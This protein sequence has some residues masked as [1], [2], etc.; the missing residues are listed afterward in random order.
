[1]PPGMGGRGRLATVVAWR[2]GADVTLARS[3][4]HDSVAFFDRWLDRADLAAVT[5]ISLSWELT[6]RA[7]VTA[8]RAAA[9]AAD[10]A[11]LVPLTAPPVLARYPTGS[12]QVRCVP[13]TPVPSAKMGH[14][15]A[16]VLGGGSDG[17]QAWF[18]VGPDQPVEF[19]AGY[20][21]DP[22]P[23]TVLDARGR[24]VATVGDVVTGG[25]GWDG[26]HH[27]W[28]GTLHRT[29]PDRRHGSL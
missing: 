11:A 25:G 1:M 16:V 3:G 23:L 24:P 12:L 2:W 9:A 8:D 21:A 14:L 19:P 26:D 5:S 29:R 4:G 6:F 13:F 20:T 15:R 10:I 7:D 18:T 27:V 17:R 28:R 22:D